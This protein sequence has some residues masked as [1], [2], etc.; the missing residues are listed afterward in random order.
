M[1]KP[2]IEDYQLNWNTPYAKALEKWGDESERDNAKYRNH[3]QR[4][5][6]VFD[7]ELLTKT[8]KV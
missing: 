8:P 4:L 7:S 5:K 3:F 6:D 1:N 2:K